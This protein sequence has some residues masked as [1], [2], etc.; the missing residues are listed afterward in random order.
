LNHRNN[1][2]CEPIVNIIH[3]VIIMPPSVISAYVPSES[4]DSAKERRCPYRQNRYLP[5]IIFHSSSAIFSPSY[6]ESNQSSSHRK[7]MMD[8]A[9]ESA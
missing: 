2:S 5:N 7:L 3:I 8:L 9:V 6:A 1:R 4:C